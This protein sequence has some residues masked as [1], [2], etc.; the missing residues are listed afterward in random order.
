[1]LADLS[2]QNQAKPVFQPTVLDN[3]AN[4]FLSRER[5]KKQVHA[6]PPATFPGGK[7]GVKSMNE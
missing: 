2:F 4:N 3:E 1:L 7:A 6:F 5:L